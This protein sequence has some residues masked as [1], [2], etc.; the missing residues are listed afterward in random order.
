MSDHQ[1]KIGQKIEQSEKQ[2]EAPQTADTPKKPNLAD[3]LKRDAEELLKE[4]HQKGLLSKTTTDVVGVMVKLLIDRG[5]EPDKSPEAL[6]EAAKVLIDLGAK[7]VSVGEQTLVFENEIDRR[8]AV[9]NGLSRSA[10]MPTLNYQS[11]VGTYGVEMR[12][13]ETNPEKPE[14][15]YHRGVL[16]KVQCWAENLIRKANDSNGG[17][18]ANLFR[19]GKRSKI[20]LEQSMEHVKELGLGGFRMENGLLMEEAADL[21][22]GVMLDDLIRY[23]SGLDGQQ[24]KF[25]D[26]LNKIEAIRS[27][28]ATLAD[29]HQRS[30]VGIGEVLANDLVIKVE[31]GK[32]SGSRLTLPDTA[33]APEV[34]ELEQ[35][36]TDML[37]FCFS[38]AS[39]GLQTGGLEKAKEYMEAGLADYNLDMVK[40][41]MKSLLKDRPAATGHNMVRLGFDRVK[42]KAAQFEEIRKVLAVLL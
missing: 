8:N 40:L 32:I 3:I 39:A 31:D 29:I 22:Q 14:L 35:K 41:A 21:R 9:L 19:K 6:A 10:V 18:L 13:D 27:A 7:K 42:E 5:I 30:K 2:A 12:I 11:N 16:S 20:E 4:A 37:D 36:A 24:N 38:L 34:D 28:G 15:V 17:I 1:N 33:Y 25:L 23:Q 26:S